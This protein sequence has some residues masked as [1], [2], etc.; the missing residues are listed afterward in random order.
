MVYP[1]S[2]QGSSHCKLQERLSQAANS[3][4][5][6]IHTR[7]E[8]SVIN[9]SNTKKKLETESTGLV[10]FS[11]APPENGE[12]KGYTDRDD[13]LLSNQNLTI[14][15]YNNC[16]LMGG[17]AIPAVQVCYIWGRNIVYMVDAGTLWGETLKTVASRCLEAPNNLTK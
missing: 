8:K 5:L 14:G 9:K 17:G 16:R 2:R 1:L 7:V 13:P 15:K 6:C 12:S 4:K 11:T 10:K 3:R